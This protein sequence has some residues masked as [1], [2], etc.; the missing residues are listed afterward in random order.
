M[1]HKYISRSGPE[2]GT[3]LY[4][5]DTKGLHNSN[6]D[7]SRETKFITHGWKSSAMNAGLVDMK[8][9]IVI[10]KI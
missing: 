5:N 4:T 9:G 7:P 6:F 10:L 3:Q 2:N 1:K 8:E